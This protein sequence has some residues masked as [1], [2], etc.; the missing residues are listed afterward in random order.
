MTTRH[1]RRRGGIG[2]AGW[3]AIIGTL[4]PAATATAQGTRAD[5][6]RSARFDERT[7]GKVY[8]ASVDPQWLPDG[9][10]FWYRRSD[11]LRLGCSRSTPDILS[12]HGCASIAYE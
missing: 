9:N 5:Y 7:R 11:Q 4:G 8:R 12:T 6:E 2:L 1:A 10:S 3:L